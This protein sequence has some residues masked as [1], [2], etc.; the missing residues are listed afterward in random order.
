[1]ALTAGDAAWAKPRKAAGA[2]GQV[3]ADPNAIPLPNNLTTS[4]DWLDDGAGN[5]ASGTLQP[6]RHDNDNYFL[7]QRNGYDPT[8]YTQNGSI[9]DN[10][11]AFDW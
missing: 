9:L 4:K 1:M 2:T 11:T 8:W 5:P 6:N 10:G 3:A 7:E